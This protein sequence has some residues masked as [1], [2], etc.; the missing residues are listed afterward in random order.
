VS[1]S[2]N[3]GGHRLPTDHRLPHV[4]WQPVGQ[5]GW[6][7]EESLREHMTLNVAVRHPGGVTRTIDWIETQVVDL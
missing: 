7:A 1:Q 5:G 4:R 6:M 3:L 2:A